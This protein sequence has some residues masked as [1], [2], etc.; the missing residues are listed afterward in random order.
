VEKRLTITEWH[1]IVVR[2]KAAEI[3]ENILVKGIKFYIEGRIKTRNGQE[4]MEMIVI[5][6]RLM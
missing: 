3:C 6:P 5:Q 4:K 1:N 2:N